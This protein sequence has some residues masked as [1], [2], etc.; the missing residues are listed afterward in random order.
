MRGHILFTKIIYGPS[1]AEILKTRGK[2]PEQIEANVMP[3]NNIIQGGGKDDEGETPG[4][5]NHA[6]FFPFLFKG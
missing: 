6:T 3:R 4:A 5:K 2:I 1:L